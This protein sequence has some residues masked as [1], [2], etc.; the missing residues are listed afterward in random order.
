MRA[1]KPRRT[2]LACPHAAIAILAAQ[3]L[4]MACAPP[5]T[6]PT[7]AAGPAAVAAPTPTASETSSAPASLPSAPPASPTEVLAKDR[8]PF[9]SCYA[10]AR[11]TDPKL[12]RTSVEMTFTIDA[13]GTPKTVDLQYRHRMDDRAKECL[14]DA[15]LAL[16]FPPSMQ[17]TRSGTIVFTPTPA[18]P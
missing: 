10:R 16:R 3:A 15:A 5:P 12:G 1:V 13:E 18:T 11:A 8:A 2:P 14:R 6:T 7:T 4:S 17:G 9:D